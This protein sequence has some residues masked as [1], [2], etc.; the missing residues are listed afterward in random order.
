MNKIFSLTIMIMCCLCGCSCSGI[1]KGIVIEDYIVGS[2][3]EIVAVDGKSPK[4]AKHGMVTTVVPLVLVSEGKH[5]LTLKRSSLKADD[6][7]IH[8]EAGP[9]IDIDVHLFE[10]HRYRVIEKDGKP[11]MVIDDQT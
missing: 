11:V 3:Y 2:P 7:G 4:R 6:G 1:N 10:G 8:K 9:P 5:V